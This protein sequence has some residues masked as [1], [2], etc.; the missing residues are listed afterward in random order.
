MEILCFDVLKLKFST[1][2]TY[3]CLKKHRKSPEN[4]KKLK[5]LKKITKN[6]ENCVDIGFFM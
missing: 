2:E 5:K 4:E 3:M 6:K 1:K